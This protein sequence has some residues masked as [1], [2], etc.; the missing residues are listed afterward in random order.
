MADPEQDAAAIARQIATIPRLRAKFFQNADEALAEAVPGKWPFGLAVRP[1]TRKLREQVRAKVLEILEKRGEIPSSSHAEA[2]MQQFFRAAIRNPERTFW[3]TLL[4]SIGAFLV[5][6]ALLVTGLVAAFVGDDNTRSTVV[7]S[8][9]GTGG[10]VGALGSVYTLT[11]RG[12]SVANANHAQIRLVLSDF[13]TELGHLRALHLRKLEDV[14][15]VNHKIREAMTHAVD[16]IQT[17]VKV[18]PPSGKP[19]PDGQQG[20]PSGQKQEETKA[21]PEA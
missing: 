8:V 20:A 7:A 12:V 13:A 2:V 4:L 9:F 5:G 17:R 11:R 6:V 14:Q 16:L 3:F 19:R 18:E 10:V 15:A 1:E 21:T